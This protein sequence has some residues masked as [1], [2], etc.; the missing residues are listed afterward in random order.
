[1]GIDYY[2]IL[3]V[4]RNASDEDLKKAYRRLAMIWHSDKN[5]NNSHAQN[6]S[7]YYNN[8]HQHLNPNF[9]FNPRNADDIYAEIFGESSNGNAAGNT[10]SSSSNGARKDGYFRNTTM[11]D[12]GAR[13]FPGGGGGGGSR[14]AMPVENALMCSLEELYA[15]LLGDEDFRNVIDSHGYV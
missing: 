2:N 4:N 13:E 8:H 10:A 5:A 1:M 7:F 14:K 15:V 12:G 6:Q 9:Q 3:K 11:N